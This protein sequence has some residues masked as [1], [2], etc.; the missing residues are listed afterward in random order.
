MLPRISITAPPTVSASNCGNCSAIRFL[1]SLILTRGVDLVR[2]R[3][4]LHD[5]RLLAVEFVLDRSDEL[6][7]DV[8]Q[9]DESGHYS[10][11]IDEERHDDARS[12]QLAQQSI[13]RRGL[14]EEGGGP[15]KRRQIIDA[16]IGGHSLEDVFDMDDPH[17]VLE[18]AVAQGKPRV[19]GLGQCFQLRFD[20]IGPVEDVDAVS[21]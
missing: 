3:A 2:V 10:V 13:Q 14:G 12:L 1:T 18:I 7:D 19:T 21:W 9:R 20:G 15:R 4:L 6:L 16:S 5:Q 17:D 11:F 8:F